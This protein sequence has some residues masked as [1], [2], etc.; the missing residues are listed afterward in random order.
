VANEYVKLGTATLVGGYPLEVIGGPDATL[1]LREPESGYSFT[2]SDLGVEELAELLA[3]ATAPKTCAHCGN[4]IVPCPNEASGTVPICKGW[5]HAAYVDRHPIGSH[6]CGA[7]S[8]NPSAELAEVVDRAAMPGQED[9][10]PP[11]DESDC[12]CGPNSERCPCEA[13]GDDGLCSCCRNGDCNGRCAAPG[14]V[15]Q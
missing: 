14:Q 13:D 10:E 5:L 12:R 6:Y 3:R 11:R 7:R 8:V 15:T 2:F 1:I 4:E 9:V